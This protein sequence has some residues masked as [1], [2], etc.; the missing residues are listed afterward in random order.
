M[1]QG[2]PGDGTQ[3]KI[4]KIVNQRLDVE[5][6]RMT[7]RRAAWFR[8]GSSTGSNTA[9]RMSSSIHSREVRR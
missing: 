4:G 7:P 8:A 9:P 6:P 1:D 2:D 5:V 3:E